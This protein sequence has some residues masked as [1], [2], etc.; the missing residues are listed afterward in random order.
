MKKLITATTLILFTLPSFASDLPPCP[1]DTYHNCFGAGAYAN[2]A[3]Y[4]GE[5][6]DNK[7]NGNGTY[8]FD[9]YK[10]TGHF[11]DG[12]RHGQGTAS[13]ASGT[14]YVGEWK[15]DIQDGWG[16]LIMP[17]GKRMKGP[18]RDGEYQ[19]EKVE[20]AKSYCASE[21]GKMNNDFSAK[22]LY[23]SCLAEVGLEP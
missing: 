16:V 19:S 10:Y 15:N 21:A 20:T 5:W 2:G 22:K 18:F 14:K 8:T 13:T 23:E 6:K 7:R 9:G 11:K 1:K 4:V 3:K 17:D 12:K